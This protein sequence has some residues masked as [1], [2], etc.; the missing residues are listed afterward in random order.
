MDPFHN[1]NK[2][3]S[4]SFGPSQRQPYSKSN[5][6]AGANAPPSVAQDL[7]R[8]PSPFGMSGNTTSGSNS[9]RNSGS[10]LSAAYYTNRSPMYSPLDFSPPVFSPNHS[11]LQQARNYAANIPVVSNLMNQSMA[12]VCEYQSHYPLFGLD[13]SV[14]DYVCLGSYKED[15]RNKLQVLHSN[16]LLSWENVVDANVVYP[17]SKIQWVPSQLHPRKLATCSDSLRIWNVNPEERHL[18]GQVNLSLCKYNRQHPTSP[19]TADDMKVIGTFPPIT[20]FDWNTVD[21]NLIISSSI[22]TTCIVWD[23][24]SSHYVKTQLIAHDSEVFDVRF[25]TKSTQLFASCGGDGSVRVFDLRSLA[26]STIIYEPPSSPASGLN[27]GTTTPSLKGSDAL[28]RL[29]PSPYDPN[30][31]A[32]FAADSNKIIILDMR[33]PESPI[34]NLEGHT[35][36]VNEIKWHPTKRNVLLSCSDDCQV[37]YWDLNNSF[38]EINGSDS[39]SPTASGASLEDSDGDTVMADGGAKANQQ[40]DPLNSNNDKQVC[41]TLDTPNMMYV[42]KTQEIN[43]IAWRPQRGDWFG[44]VSGKKFQNVRVF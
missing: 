43:N 40:E 4:I 32:T 12:S 37:L 19:A 16:D 27:A 2:R 39:K 42:N 22:D 26:H 21:T 30:V 29:E 6:L 23:L 9:K 33:N 34:L 25:L 10:D 7:G 11:Q 41:R 44:C 14:D 13:W 31:L 5:Y 1:G 3:S 15:S 28:L 18:Q 35:C 17:V 20:S 38:M 24:Q 36:S 8:G